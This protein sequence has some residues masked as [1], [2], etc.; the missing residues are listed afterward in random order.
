MY[1]LNIKFK[2]KYEFYTV[3]ICHIFEYKS[4][5]NLCSRRDYIVLDFKRIE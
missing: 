4:F 5:E 3:D 2:R 1:L